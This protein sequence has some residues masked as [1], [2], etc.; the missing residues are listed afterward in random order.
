VYL[1]WLSLT[2][3]LSHSEDLIKMYTVVEQQ[4]DELRVKLQ[5]K[6]SE[7]AA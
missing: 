5:E 7:E 1:T 4:L 3:S 6:V 2:H